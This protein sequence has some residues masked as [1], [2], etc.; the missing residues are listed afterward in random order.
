MMS[1]QKVDYYPT[2][3]DIHLM[4]KWCLFFIAKTLAQ[5]IPTMKSCK[6]Y[7][8]YGDIF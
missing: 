2:A 5:Y 4:E 7:I 6:G 8:K 3:Q 1:A